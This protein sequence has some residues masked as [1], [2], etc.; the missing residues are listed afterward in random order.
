MG[1]EVGATTS[2][3][4]YTANMRSYLNATGRAGV[5]KA[6][7]EAAAKGFLSA[8]EGA[9][10][11]EVIEIVSPS[12]LSSARL[13]RRSPADWMVPLDFLRRTCLSS[14]LT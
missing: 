6:A 13:C 14:S 10:Y 9:E 12:Y 5:A 7:D 11:D 1:A 3:F 2:T 8:D 4:P